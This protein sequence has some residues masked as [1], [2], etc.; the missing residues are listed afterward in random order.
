[1][2]RRGVSVVAVAGL[3]L[4]TGLVAA[5][6]RPRLQVGPGMQ[7]RPIQVGQLETM[8]SLELSKQFE[9]A[10]KLRNVSGDKLTAAIEQY[11]ELPGDLQVQLLYVTDERYAQASWRNEGYSI[12]RLNPRIFADISRLRLFGLSYFWPD[13]GAPGAWSF[14]FGHGFNDACTV[15]FD[16][17]PVESNYLGMNVEFFPNSMAFKVPAN[18]TR[19]Q[20][21]NVFVRN[22]AADGGD[23]ATR[24]YEIV[25]PRGYRGYHG[26]QFPNFSRGA[27]LI[28]WYLYS[29]YFGRLAVEYPDGTHRP[30][31]DQWYNDVWGRSGTG[32]NCFGMSVASMRLRNNELDHMYYDSY[33]TA[34][35]T[36]HTWVWFYPWNSTTKETVQ[37]QQAA[38]YVQEVAARINE[39]RNTTTARDVFTRSQSLLGNATNRP[40]LGYWSPTWGHA[41]CPYS[42]EVVGDDHRMMCYDNNNPYRENESGSVDPDIATVHWGANTF[43]RGAGNRAICLSFDEATPPDPH[44]PGAA[45]DGPAADTVI[46]AFGPGSRVTQITDEDGRLAFNADG[47][48]NENPATRI[49]N[50]MV[51][52][53]MEQARPQIQL[54]RVRQLQ[55]S[56]SGGQSVLFIVGNSGGKTLTFDI[57]ATAQTSLSYFEPGE[58]FALNTTGVG[59]V[60]FESLLNA[61]RARLQQLGAGA[62]ADIR[63]INSRSSG[64]RLFELGNFQN[65]SGP[66]LRLIPAP[67][68]STLDVQGPPNLRFNLNI[69]GPV[70]QGAQQVRFANVALEAGAAARLAP[71]N[72]NALGATSL[73]L[74]MVNVQNNQIIRQETIQRIR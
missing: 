30:A 63:F 53:E 20:M 60:Q 71:D 56:T 36:A 50:S 74:Q 51:F 19:D 66:E 35:A 45:L 64:D 70:G 3:M 69:S 48:P 42:T 27:N 13:Q 8:G 34:P 14:A 11:R 43:S 5:Q 18:A 47:T 44:L 26:W 38:Q 54:P 16:G 12:T 49:P 59:Q 2:M 24:Q 61:P 6:E 58:V 23:T 72:W 25:A 55:V 9:Q 62:S 73:R 67:D 17:S 52:R 41:I 31:A 15:Y 37:Q 39:L 33:F 22:T 7:A 21:H 65:L 40:I 10:L 57:P 29:D 68:G 1:V 46:I 28:P 32:G 4:V